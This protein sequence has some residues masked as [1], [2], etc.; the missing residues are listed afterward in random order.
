MVV[1]T[2]LF[3]EVDNAALPQVCLISAAYIPVCRTVL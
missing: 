3:S 1:A 2:N